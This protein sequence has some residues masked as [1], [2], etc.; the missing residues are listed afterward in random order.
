MKV[1]AVL[2][3]ALLLTACPVFAGGISGGGDGGGGGG[4]VSSVS[5]TTNQLTCTP[6]TGAVVCGLAATITTPGAINLGANPLAFL[7][8]ATLID[9]E[10]ASTVDVRNGINA[11]KTRFFNTYTATTNNEFVTLDWQAIS[12]VVTLY[13]DKNG[14]GSTRPLRLAYGGF[15]STIGLQIGTAVNGGVLVSSIINASSANT[16]GRMDVGN[17]STNNS[18][19]GNSITL[20]VR[21]SF[22]PTATSSM[23]AVPVSIEPTINYSNGTPGAGSYE[24]LHIAVTETALP[25]GTNYMLRATGGAAGAT[26]VW[27]VTNTGNEAL[28]G[29]LTSS[30]STDLGW[31]IVNAA[32][33]ACNTT[34]TS[35]CVFG[36]NTAAIGVLL[37]CTDA[38]ADS[39]LCAGAS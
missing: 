20:R 31:S 39:C 2:L 24:A 22:N 12:N 15:P 14:A 18:T 36:F 6:T 11:T 19:S 9:G 33:Q 16:L 29:T 21:E 1:I 38:T 3:A 4:A 37:A 17:L 25:T 32:N 13:T 26:A 8:G 23:V 30:R 28:A 34:C 7:N 5:G 27:S 10:T 35:A